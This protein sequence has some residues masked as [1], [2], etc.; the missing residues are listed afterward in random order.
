MARGPTPTARTFFTGA[1][2]TVFLAIAGRVVPEMTALDDRAVGDALALVEHQLA[3][4][5]EKMRRELAL[6]LT[7]IRWAPVLRFGRPF[8][9]LDASRQDAILRWLQ[10]APVTTL[11]A[12]LWGLK[13]L[14]F[15][16]YYGRPAAADAIHYRPSHDGN[17]FLHAR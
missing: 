12:G 4:R 9:R 13:T 7:A 15:L 16:G 2:Q 1:R 14:A 3:G 11:R 8:D 10:D 6:F 5:P 17:A